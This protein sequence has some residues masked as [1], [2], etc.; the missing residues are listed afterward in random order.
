MLFNNLIPRTG[1][2][3]NSGHPDQTGEGDALSPHTCLDELLRKRHGLGVNVGEDAAHGGGPCGGDYGE[4][5]LFGPCERFIASGEG[6]PFALFS[7]LVAT[8]NGGSCVGV[9]GL[10]ECDSC[11]VCGDD[12]GTDGD[13]G[14]EEEFDGGC[15]GAKGWPGAVEEEGGWGGEGEAHA[16][17]FGCGVDRGVVLGF[18]TLDVADI[19]MRAV[20]HGFVMLF[21]VLVQVTCFLSDSLSV[22][23]SE[24]GNECCLLMH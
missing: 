19:S 22:G 16:E 5:V 8:L 14:D 3:R 15:E 1:D 23:V 24:R 4:L 17:A 7:G 12:A 9:V 18:S 13:G 20:R 21:G 10:I 6:V 2:L 11:F